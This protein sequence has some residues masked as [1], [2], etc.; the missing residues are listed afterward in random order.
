MSSTAVWAP[1]RTA[2][3]LELDQQRPTDAEPACWLAEPEVLDLAAIGASMRTPPQ[4]TAIGVEHDEKY[5]ARRGERVGVGRDH[6]IARWRIRE[7]PLAVGEVLVEEFP[8]E[9]IVDG[10]R[11]VAGHEDQATP[12]TMGSMVSKVAVV[13]ATGRMGRLAQQLIDEADDLELHAAIGSSDSLDGIDGADIV[14]DVTVPAVSPDVVVRGT[15]PRHPDS[16]RHVGLDRGSHRHAGAPRRR[17]TTQPAVVLIPNFSLGSALATAFATLA[18]P[19]FEFIEIVES[20][21]EGKVDSPS[22]TA[23]RTAELIGSRDSTRDRSPPRTPTSEPAGRPWR[24]SRFTAFGM[25]GFRRA[26]RSCS[27]ARGRPCDCCT[28]RHSD[29]S[30]RARNPAG[31]AR[32]GVRARRRRRIGSAHRPRRSA[33]GCRPR[34]IDCVKIRVAVASWRRCSRCTSSSPCNTESC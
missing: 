1:R 10:G 24:A 22:G 7:L 3:A 16:R 29:A 6:G 26:R 8:R 34:G 17:P 23:I 14:F 20:H 15:R 12:P 27:A 19:W 11:D 31:A 2:R 21:H 4:P 25:P 30:L 32:G 28:T 33:P 9:G 5:P 18:A 13:G